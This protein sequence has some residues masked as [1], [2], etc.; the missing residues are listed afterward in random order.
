MLTMA[1]FLALAQILDEK[2]PDLVVKREEEEKRVRV[3]QRLQRQMGNVLRDP[4]GG[5]GRC[6]IHPFDKARI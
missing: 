3:S 2:V 1:P 5:F 4:E 6:R